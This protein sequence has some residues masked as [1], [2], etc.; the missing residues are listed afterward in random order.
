MKIVIMDEPTKGVDVGAK[1]EIY[2]IMGDLAKQGYGIILISS[3][4]AKS[5]SPD[6][7]MR[8]RFA[9][10]V[11]LYTIIGGSVQPLMISRTTWLQEHGQDGVGHGIISI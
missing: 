9:L 8:R 5:C 10:S 7:K 6:T 2:A 4:I 11:P 1:A 3:D